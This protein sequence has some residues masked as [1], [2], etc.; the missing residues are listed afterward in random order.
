MQQYEYF[1]TI[2]GSNYIV[3]DTHIKFMYN[4]ST[5]CDLCCFYLCCFGQLGLIISGAT[6]DEL[7]LCFLR[8]IFLKAFLSYPSLNP[9]DILQNYIG[10]AGL[11]MG[12]RGVHM[13]IQERRYPVFDMR[14]LCSL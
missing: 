1:S 12:V 11:F 3:L 2:C 13:P 9:K 7:T 4:I 10:M 14:L 8:I 5:A 6:I